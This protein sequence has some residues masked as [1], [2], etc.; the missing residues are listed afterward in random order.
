MLR[1]MPEAQNA[2]ADLLCDINSDFMVGSKFKVNISY[3]QCVFFPTDAV[4]P[5]DPRKAKKNEH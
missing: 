4:K 3:Y 1:K 5:K 2:F